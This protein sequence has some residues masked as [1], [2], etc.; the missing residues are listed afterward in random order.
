MVKH[1]QLILPCDAGGGEGPAALWWAEA[2]DC[3]CEGDAEEP[4]DPST[5]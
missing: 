5:G 1:S 3:D 2:E 4:G